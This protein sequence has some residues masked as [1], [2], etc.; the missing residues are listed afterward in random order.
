MDM[1]DSTLTTNFEVSC[2][3][4]LWIVPPHSYLTP[5]LRPFYLT[6]TDCMKG[7]PCTSPP[8]RALPPG[9]F[10]IHHSTNTFYTKPLLLVLIVLIFGMLQFQYTL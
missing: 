4:E 6:V 5:S 1:L 3:G 2:S 9:F 8:L 10:I 7:H